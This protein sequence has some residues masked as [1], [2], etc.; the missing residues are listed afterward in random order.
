[1]NRKIAFVLSIIKSGY[2]DEIAIQI[3]KLQPDGN[4]EQ[5]A[6]Q[7]STVLSKLK[8]QKLLTAIKEGRKYRYSLN[9]E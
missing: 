2:R 3:A 6:K 5:I 9:A 7:L 4:K 8:S 1:M